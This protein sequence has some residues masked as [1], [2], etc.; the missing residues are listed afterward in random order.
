MMKKIFYITSNALLI[1]KIFNFLSWP[2]EHEAK[3][4]DKKDQV[5]FKFYD[6]TVWLTNNRN[7]QIPQYFNQTMKFG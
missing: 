1:L 5:N 7:T 3:R 2:S 4:L 6:V